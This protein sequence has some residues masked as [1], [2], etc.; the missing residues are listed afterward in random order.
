MSKKLIWLLA[1]FMAV[2]MA[3]LILV[4]TYWIN[5]AIAIKEKQFNQI[6]NHILDNLSMEIEKRETVLHVYQQFNNQDP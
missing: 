4:Q 5:N 3:A 2:G 6:V 1:G